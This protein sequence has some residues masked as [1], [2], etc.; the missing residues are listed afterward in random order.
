ML[1]IKEKSKKLPNAPLKTNIFWQNTCHKSETQE[2]N[3]FWNIK[4]QGL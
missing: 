2:P 4:G 3:I 1:K